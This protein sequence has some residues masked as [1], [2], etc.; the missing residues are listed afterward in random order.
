MSFSGV[1]QSSAKSVAK[2][3]RK[4][5]RVVGTAAALTLTATGVLVSQ[6][7]AAAADFHQITVWIAGAPDS[8]VAT[9]VGGDGS[10]ALGVEPGARMTFYSSDANQ[11]QVG[12]GATDSVLGGNCS[13]VVNEVQSDRGHGKWVFDVTCDNSLLNYHAGISV[14]P[15]SCLAAAQQAG[16]LTSSQNYNVT[17]TQWD[18]TSG[19]G[20]NGTKLPYPLS[21]LD[22]APWG[23]SVEAY[24]AEPGAAWQNF[25][26]SVTELGAYLPAVRACAPAGLSANPAV[27]GG[28]IQVNPT[29]Q[30]VSNG[31]AAWFTGATTTPPGVSG[32]IR[33][34]AWPRNLGNS[35]TTPWGGYRNSGYGRCLASNSPATQNCTLTN[36][37]VTINAGGTGGGFWSQT[38]CTGQQVDVRDRA[39][40]Y[41][42]LGLWS[43]A[44]AVNLTGC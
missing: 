34:L 39:T 20:A 33:F 12:L 32:F 9:S 19:A 4:L 42:G 43:D 8:L 28:A 18:L 31:G 14:G 3:S 2:R 25:L 35:G 22:S 27:S 6:G 40:T 15:A 7:P 21:G 16:G 30:P 23:N 44:N 29:N 26:P 10:D 5:R 1:E 37:P 24:T 11:F 38:N 13:S 36:I 41:R 17:A